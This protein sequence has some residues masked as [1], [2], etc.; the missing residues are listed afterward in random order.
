MLIK[1]MFHFNYINTDRAK[2][3]SENVQSFRSTAWLSDPSV[4]NTGDI[5]LKSSSWRRLT[6]SAKQRMKSSC[7]NEAD[8]IFSC[9]NNFNFKVRLGSMPQR[10]LNQDP[11]D[12]ILESPGGF[13]DSPMCVWW[14]CGGCGPGSCRCSQ[15]TQRRRRHHCR[16]TGVGPGAL[17]L[18]HWPQTWRENRCFTCFLTPG[19][20]KQQTCG[21][22]QLFYINLI[23]I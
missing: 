8:L 9:F 23:F 12:Y 7:F 15:R 3:R 14:L 20:Q 21:S 19:Q 2:I 11:G 17:H 18:L 1:L 6:C 4:T 22:F 16:L 5:I 10:V 13:G